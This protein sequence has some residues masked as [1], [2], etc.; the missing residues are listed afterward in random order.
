VIWRP[1]GI[2]DDDMLD[3]IGGCL[4]ALEEVSVPLK[5]FV[6]FSDLNQFAFR[7]S[8]LFHFAR[9]RTEQPAGIGAVRT[10]LFSDGYIGFGLA[11]M[12]EALMRIQRSKHT[13]FA[14]V[15]R[16][17]TGWICRLIF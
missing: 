10:A 4:V 9:K 1:E 14:T 5:R 12:Y 16:Q 15:L 6:D 2:L 7:T 13:L 8:H 17:P 11:R 3:Q